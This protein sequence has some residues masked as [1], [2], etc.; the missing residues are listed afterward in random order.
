M[1]CGRSRFHGRRWHRLHG[2][3][4]H[5]SPPPCHPT[6]CAPAATPSCSLPTP[7][8][9][10]TSLTGA[11]RTTP[12]RPRR[13]KSPTTRSRVRLSGTQ[14]CLVCSRFG[15]QRAPDP[16]LRALGTRSPG[17]SVSP[18]QRCG[19]GAPDADTA[20]R[21][22]AVLWRGGEPFLRRWR[23]PAEPA[24]HAEPAEPGAAVQVHSTGNDH[25]DSRGRRMVST[26]LPRPPCRPA[27]HFA[28][29]G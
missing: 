23:E 10:G 8:S 2:A 7:A 25:S 19:T 21:P 3:D 1:L 20:H 17:A 22:S 18:L 28:V 29:W 6:C 14:V 12:A 16:R 15:L 9:S 26:P 4:Q 5:P 27:L 11:L 24:E 13:R